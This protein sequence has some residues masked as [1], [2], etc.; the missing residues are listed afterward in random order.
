MSWSPCFLRFVL[1]AKVA[2]AAGACRPQPVAEVSTVRQAHHDVDRPL[3]P[4]MGFADLHFHMMAEE[5][6][7]GGWLHG[8]HD[9]SLHS[10]D[11]GFDHAR[12]VPDLYDRMK[13]CN[14]G[15][16]PFDFVNNLQLRAL[17]TAAGAVGGSEAIGMTEGS[18]G[19]TGLHLHRTT[20]P[21]GWPRWDTIAHQQGATGWLRS[22]HERGLRLVVMSAVSFDWLCSIIPPGNRRASC[23]EMSD[24]ERQ[25][26]MAH[27]LAS[28]HADWLEIALDPDHA[29]RIIAGGKLAMVLSI[30][31]SHIFGRDVNASNLRQRLDQM[32]A[33]GVR[34]LQPVHQTDNA[35]GGAALHN[36]IFQL[37]QYT[38]SESPLRC[39]VDMDC[40]ATYG[41]FTL[42][43]DVDE[44]C[45]NQRGLTALG[46]TLIS[47]MMARGMLIDVAHLSERGTDRVF[48]LARGNSYYPVYISHGHFR[49]IMTPDVALKEKSTPESVIRQLRETGGIFGL[50]TAHD[51]TL[52]YEKTH[53]ANNCHGSSRSFAQAYE[54]GRQGLRVP[55]A[56]G[57]DLN[58]FIQQTRPRFG[59]DGACSA[60][61]KAE[62]DCQARAQRQ[63]GPGRLGTS[64]DETGLAHQGMLPDLVDDLKNLGV[65][66]SVL[67][68]SAEAFLAMWHRA[69]GPRHGPA[70]LNPT[71][72]SSGITPFVSHDERKK[73]YPTICGQAYCSDH[74]VIGGE[75]RFDAECESNQCT[76][77]GCGVVPGRCVCNNDGDCAADRFCAGKVPGIPGDNGCELRR[78]DHATCTRDRQCASGQCGGFIGDS[79]WCFSARSKSV[80]QGCRVNEECAT[81]RCIDTAQI[82]GCT[83]EADCASHEFCNRLTGR[84][85]ERRGRG[86]VCSAD[87]QCKSGNCNGLHLCG[88]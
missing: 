44:T 30:E 28:R 69:T 88:K 63:Q 67:E 64:F 10:C 62:A 70:E 24:V 50:R 11:G 59:V 38:D 77:V 58:G 6:F 37:A 32:H 18:Q 31:A 86:A 55:M 25:L 68:S 17:F 87:F 51:E 41:D 8:A 16:P 2:F 13:Q 72:D 20:H 47:E 52:T 48:E 78:G 80:G 7:G 53:V 71:I 12:V 45:R 19:D 23:D 61:F 56:F 39:H 83:G 1:A 84:C 79:G 36:P 74:Q 5:A 73:S 66:T 49:E 14:P 46:E 4:I 26:R 60:S 21:G 57:A 40:G 9:E 29:R 27:D 54:Y 42:G 33:L 81:N 65:D 76:A 34:T 15:V 35:F 82:C 43:F 75:C 22:A 3:A 85:V